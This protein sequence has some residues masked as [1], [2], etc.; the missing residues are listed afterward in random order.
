[1]SLK[2][3]AHSH[4]P[5]ELPL[6]EMFLFFLQPYRYLSRSDVSDILI[7]AH[8]APKPVPHSESLK[9]DFYPILMPV[10]LNRPMEVSG[11]RW[12]FPDW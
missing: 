7:K 3:S 2:Q 5:T 6:I 9:S 4:F 10:L 12:N 8:M 11:F 1:M